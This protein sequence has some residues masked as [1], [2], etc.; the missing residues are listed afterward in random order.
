ME[1]SL[2]LRPP[3]KS[4]TSVHNETSPLDGGVN[5]RCSIY[6]FKNP[7]SKSVEYA[8]CTLTSVMG[9]Q[10]ST[11]H[12]NAQPIYYSTFTSTDSQRS[13][14]QQEQQSQDHSDGGSLYWCPVQCPPL[15]QQQQQRGYVPE[16]V[17][18]TH[19]YDFCAAASATGR[20]SN[21]TITQPK[22][23]STDEG[24]AARLGEL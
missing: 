9:L 11:A 8:V 14:Q 1:L 4:S 16:N 22:F 20:S 5:V 3:P 19:Q 10:A 17:V 2:H 15:Q 13:Q 6:A 24:Y 7:Y 12:T 21:V 23:L 18:S